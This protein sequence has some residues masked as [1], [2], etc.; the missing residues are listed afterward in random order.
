MSG[1]A[2]GWDE[3]APLAG[4][5]FSQ[6]N[7]QKRAESHQ[8]G[9]AVLGVSFPLTTLCSRRKDKFSS[10]IAIADGAGLLASLPGN[11]PLT[12]Y[13]FLRYHRLGIKVASTVPTVRAQILETDRGVE[14]MSR[15]NVVSFGTVA[16]R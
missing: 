2:G 9:H 6:E 5:S 4:T 1:T 8:S 12:G 7:A 16:E 14:E 15:M 13:W 11:S 3:I 10:Y